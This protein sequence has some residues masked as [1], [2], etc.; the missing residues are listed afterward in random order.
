VTTAEEFVVLLRHVRDRSGLSYRTIAKRAELAGAVL[1]ASTLATM[2]ARC[3]HADRRLTC[4]PDGPRTT[5]P[6]RRVGHQGSV[7][8]PYA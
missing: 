1:P 6:I 8:C 2:L 4:A 7:F 3:A 5:L